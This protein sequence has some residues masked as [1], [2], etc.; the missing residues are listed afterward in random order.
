M[1]KTTIAKIPW[2]LKKQ[3]S[4]SATL[5]TFLSKVLMLA[6]NIGTRVITV[7]FLKTNARGEQALIVLWSQ[8]LAFMLTLGLPSALIY[9]LKR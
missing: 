6:T 3:D 1:I 8:L 9:N 7:R 4:N 2:L 5:Q